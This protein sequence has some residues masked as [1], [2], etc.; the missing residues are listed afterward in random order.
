MDLQFPAEVVV[1]IGANV[2]ECEIAPKMPKRDWDHMLGWKLLAYSATV[3]TDGHL[4]SSDGYIL[5]LKVNIEFDNVN[6]IG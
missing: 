4:P 6:P 5:T 2:S 3:H 1:A